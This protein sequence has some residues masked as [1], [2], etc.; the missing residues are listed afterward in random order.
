[1]E[2][3][4]GRSR[5]RRDWSGPSFPKL[6]IFAVS[7]LIFIH[8]SGRLAYGAGQFNVYTCYSGP[9]NSPI[10]SRDINTI[11]TVGSGINNAGT[12]VG[13][14]ELTNGHQQSY[15]F[16]G[17]A[18]YLFDYP[19]ARATYAN[20]INDNGV[21]VGSWKDSANHEHGFS[22]LA[23]GTVTMSRVVPVPPSKESAAT[24][25]PF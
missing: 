17:G 2:G 18:C 22:L 1:M 5:T 6:T 21:I 11:Y 19:N 24:I 7:V 25:T 4:N 13:D 12:I 10:T 20:A 9:T 14:I 15:I 23:N 16:L 8:P 3:S